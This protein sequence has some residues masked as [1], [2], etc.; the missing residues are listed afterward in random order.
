MITGIVQF[1]EAFVGLDRPSCDE[2]GIRSTSAGA[3]VAAVDRWRLVY[4]PDP[5]ANA[6]VRCDHG[7]PT[8]PETRGGSAPSWLVDHSRGAACQNAPMIA[9]DGA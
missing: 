9:E 1:E 8:S 2:N 7:K 4:H 3:L 5:S 6:T